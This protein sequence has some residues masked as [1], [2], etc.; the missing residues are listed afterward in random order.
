MDWEAD[1]RGDKQVG[2]IAKALKRMLRLRMFM[3][4][5]VKGWRRGGRNEARK[6]WLFVARMTCV[7]GC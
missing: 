5:L 4:H 6:A 1:A 7:R 2:A 3:K